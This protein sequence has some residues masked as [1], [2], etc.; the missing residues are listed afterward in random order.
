[1]TTYPAG[2]IT[3]NQARRMMEGKEPFI[4][5]RS[6]D[7]LT[8][9]HLM[10]PL[11]PIHG[12][13][14]GVTIS[15]DSIK[16]LI[17]TW[18]MLD[19]QGFN[20]DGVTFNDAVGEPI[21]IDMSVDASGLTEQSARR[22]I[23]D[24]IASWDTHETGEL[25]IYT[26]EHG[27]WWGDV[28][29]LKAPTDTLMAAFTRRQRFLWTARVD[30]GYWRS[31]DSVGQFGFQYEA[32]FDT[33]DTNYNSGLGANWPVRYF[34]PG[35]VGVIYASNGAARW[36]D[37]VAVL[38]QSREVVVGPYKNFNTATDNQVVSMTMGSML[39][40]GLPV[41]A[42]NDIWARMGRNQDGTWNGHGVRARISGRTAEIATFT[43]FDGNNNPIKTVL[44]SR[45]LI[46]PP[47]AGDRF[48][49]IAG[50][51]GNE[52]LIK[53]T[54]NN[55]DLLTIKER[56]AAM[57]VGSAYRGIGFGMFAAAALGTQRSPGSVRRIAADDNITINQEGFISLTNIGD[58]KAYPRYLCY[59]PGK[60]FIGNGPG[61][62]DLVEFG[63]LVDGQVVLIETEPRRRSVIDVSPNKLPE[64]VLT[65]SQQSLKKL[66]NLATNNN[67]PPLLRE[68]QNAFGILPPQV[69]L[70]SLMKG[71][72][73]EGIEA[74]PSNSPATTSTIKVQ[75]QGG[76]ASSK[77]IGAIT[78]KR[79]WPL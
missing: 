4:C 9:W 51:A 40:A 27:M 50:F 72:F 69:P 53:L 74:R 24:W 33:F 78:P 42:Y 67:V 41:G 2:E 76:N 60:F 25:S 34:G 7:G 52:R 26:P 46:V 61:N 21:E 79:R 5:Y 38:T 29:W 23:R 37:S 64:Q 16:G 6:P 39:E 56:G 59:G 31:Y 66:I 11:A 19:Q 8:N 47:V 17:G 22:V 20:Q 73:T 43:G 57:S 3:L 63:P 36:L 77:I 54:R 70:Y 12:I 13:Q 55:V 62:S 65:P 1:M 15:E 32:V 44:A 14:D 45:F 49:L 68:Y 48:M 71:R 30:D 28:R 75:I 18:A 35:S 10:G 58:V